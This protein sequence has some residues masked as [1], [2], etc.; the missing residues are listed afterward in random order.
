MDDSADTPAAR[1]ELR[2]AAYCVLCNR[3]VERSGDGRCA[4]GH[5]PQALTG[6]LP[7]QEGQ[8]LPQLQGF[9]WAAFLLPA[10]WG[11]AH[12]QWAGLFFLPIWLFVDSSVASASVN[13]VTLAVAVIVVATTLAFQAVFA[14]RANGMAWRRVWASMSVEEFTRRQRLW[15]LACAPSATVLLMGAAYYRFS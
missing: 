9:N 15:T 6:K 7:L 12:G 8:S 11:P 3:I 5:P 13:S 10:V 2:S 14:R 4:A 1:L